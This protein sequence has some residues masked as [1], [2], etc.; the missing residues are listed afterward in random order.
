MQG[1]L[2]TLYKKPENVPHEVTTFLKAATNHYAPKNLKIGETLEE[3]HRYA[4]LSEE[5]ALGYRYTQKES[6]NND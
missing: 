3:A 6:P 1:L 5:I 4:G 2:R